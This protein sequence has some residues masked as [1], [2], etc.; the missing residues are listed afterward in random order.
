[1]HM[2]RGKTKARE[3]RLT[4]KRKMTRR[5]NLGKE[6]MGSLRT[7]SRTGEGKLASKAGATS[8]RK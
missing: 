4:K 6:R 7:R 3:S 1:M 8:M 2:L 5:R